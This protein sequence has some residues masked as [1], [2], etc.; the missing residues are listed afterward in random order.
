M[1][2]VFVQGVGPTKLYLGLSAT[3]NLYPEVVTVQMNTKNVCYEHES[4]PP[5]K[6]LDTYRNHH[7]PPSLQEGLF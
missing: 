1:K 2:R 6:S 3:S 7:M 5:V 4:T